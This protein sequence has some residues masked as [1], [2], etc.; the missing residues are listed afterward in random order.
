VGANRDETLQR[1]R[2]ERQILANLEHANICRLLD[3]GTTE[4]GSPYVVMEYIEG[5]PIT[6]YCDRNK[7][8]ITERLKLFSTASSAVQFAHQN[9]V[10]HRDLK[11]ENILITEDGKAKLLDFGIAKL[12]DADSSSGGFKLTRTGLLPMTPEYASPEQVRGDRITTASDV[13]SLGVVL[14]EL[15][16]GHR[17]Y[18]LT[19]RAPSETGD[20]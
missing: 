5:T 15:L 8:S 16:T 17:P 10:I 2:L 18:K 14:Y 3:S 20:H 19:G 6:D 7:L 9:L 4:E 1:F 12:L 11:P 13:Y